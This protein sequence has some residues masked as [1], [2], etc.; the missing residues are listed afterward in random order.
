M[1]EHTQSVISHRARP[2]V[3]FLVGLL[4]AIAA[5]CALWPAY[6]AFLPVEIG[7]NEGW[8][9]YYAD[10]ALGA[11]PL[12]PSED[13]LITNN[14]PPLSFYL[15]GVFGRL[16]GDPVIAGRLLSLG[17]VLMI[18]VGIALLIG[19]F[20]AGG[21]GAIVGVA[22][23]VGTLSRFAD[24][25]V[26]YNDP[27]LLAQ[28]VM[29]AGF[30]MFL[31]ATDRGRGFAAPILI[32]V[33]AGFI[34]HNIVS[35]PLTALIWLAWRRGPKIAAL[36]AALGLGAMVLGFAACAMAYGPD[37]LSNMLSPRAYSWKRALGSLGYLHWIVVALLAWM[38]V[39]WTQRADSRVKLC[40]L[41]VGI[42]FSSFVLQKTGSKVA[43]NAMFDLIIALSV[44]IGLTF[45]L[46]PKLSLARRFR[47]EILQAALILAIAARLVT[48]NRFE[49]FRFV[50]DPS[51]QTEIAAREAAM[52]ESIARVRAAPG[53]VICTN[54]S[55]YRAG[56]SFAVDEIN[57]AE[58]IR[59]GTLPPDALTRRIQSGLL[60]VVEPAHQ[61]WR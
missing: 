38:Y 46:A 56:K 57:L 61:S 52:A 31:G 41:W 49:P 3:S 7:I 20:K 8:N 34:K 27:Q 33:V 11:M 59:A 2:L 36:Y 29:M 37:F 18:A 5:I 28:A 6:R 26:G 4:C 25:Y 44:G 48:H 16:F 50:F 54:L 15:V 53:E 39:G 35:M 10:A 22:F 13:K 47:P 24:R 23:F 9:A 17:A 40:N 12:Y 58:R 14:Y 1:G 42:A 21:M 51:F 30:C 32:M 43:E 55:C 60:Q 19:R 45:G